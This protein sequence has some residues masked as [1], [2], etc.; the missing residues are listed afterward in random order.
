MISRPKSSATLALGF[1]ESKL[2]YLF[3]G[4]LE[5]ACRSIAR[6]G[7]DAVEL[8]V[9]R[10]D[11]LSAA[12]LHTCLDGHSL[13]LSAIGTGGAWIAGKLHLCSPDPAI[14]RAAADFV[15]GIIDLAAR[16]QAT[17]ILGLVTGLL[18]PGVTY[19]EALDWLVPGL[20]QLAHH[21]AERGVGLVIEPL[22][23]YES[24]L[25]NRVDDGLNLLARV[26]EENIGLLADLFHM[27]IEEPSL[28][29]AI[30]RAD[31]RIR[32]VH[33]SDS[34]RRAPGMGHTDFGSVVQALRETGYSGYISSEVFPQPDAE[35][36]AAAAHA[37]YQVWFR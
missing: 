26:G 20:R 15:Q 18:E 22:N 31:G 30:R 6:H 32:H 19:D 35:T 4:P 24:N 13:Q 8:L 5:P 36:A 34:N 2:P 17:V 27:N 29:E 14:R 28:P 33:F 3:A 1:G 16:F 10:P 21:A 7:F 25:I 11:F 9:P 12:K 37:A 23:R